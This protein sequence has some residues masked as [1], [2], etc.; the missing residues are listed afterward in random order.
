MGI[1][2]VWASLPKKPELVDFA[3][4]ILLARDEY[5]LSAGTMGRVGGF[6]AVVVVDG[7]GAMGTGAD[8]LGAVVTGL[9]DF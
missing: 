8:V 1:V 5:A 3:G 4:L 2:A 6:T 9:C 7:A